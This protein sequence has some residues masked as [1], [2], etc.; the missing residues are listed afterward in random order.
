MAKERDKSR[1][2]SEYLEKVYHQQHPILALMDVY[3]VS[4]VIGMIS[5]TTQDVKER[6]IAEDLSEAV[7]A[8]FYNHRDEIVDFS[9][10]VAEAEQ[11]ILDTLKKVTRQEA[12][13][14]EHR[15]D[16]H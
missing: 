12:E 7:A 9:K 1:T 4:V 8:F 10:T 15:K 16:L 3:K 5:E 11:L 6:K 14:N 2:L 13:E